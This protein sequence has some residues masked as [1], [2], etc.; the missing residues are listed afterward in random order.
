MRQR[1]Q[2]IHKVVDAKDI[3]L[4]TIKQYTK[5]ST[6]FFES[7]ISTS[8]QL[9][10]EIIM[11]IDKNGSITEFA[12]KEQLRIGYDICTVHSIPN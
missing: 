2:L 12:S 7:T 6:R 9:N 4:D 3:P 8:F 11:Y 10:L 1:T 5:F